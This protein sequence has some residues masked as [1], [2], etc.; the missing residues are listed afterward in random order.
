MCCTNV[1][2]S[3][4]Q[5][6][7][8]DPCACAAQVEM[9]TYL[10]SVA[11]GPCLKIEVLLHVVSAIF[12]LSPSM[13]TQLPVPL[14]KRCVGVALDILAILGPNSHIIIDEAFDGSA[15]K[16][17]CHL[18]SIYCRSADVMSQYRRC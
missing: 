4:M 8:T 15:G 13:A 1:C 2:L 5:R 9:L 7:C 16:R 3:C 6:A 10:A 17:S 14:W 12:D 18:H 11:Q